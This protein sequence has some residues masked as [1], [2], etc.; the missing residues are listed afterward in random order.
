MPRPRR[1]LP[2]TERHQNGTHYVCWYDDKA[3]R[4][5]RESLGTKDDAAARTAFARFLTAGPKSTRLV[6]PAGVTV[7]QVLEWYD[8]QHVKPNVVDKERQR[9]AMTHLNAF[10]GD[11]PIARIDVEQS[12]AYATARRAGATSGRVGSDSTIRR[13]LNVLVAAATHARHWDRITDADLPRVDLPA[14]TK[15]GQVKWLTKEQIRGSLDSSTGLLHDFILIGYYTGARRASVEWL[16]KTQVDL[17][18]SRI[19]LQGPDDAVTKK[20][21]PKVPIF[22]EIRPTVERLMET[23]G[24]YLIGQRMYKP[25]VSHMADIGIEAHP[26]MLRHSRATHMLMD[27]EDPYKVAKLLGDTLATIER[28]YGHFAPEYLATKSNIGVA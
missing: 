10:M 20:R 25:F 14:E 12:R 11:T 7:R 15:G 26:H 9:D 13:E 24:D 17:R 3:R 28:V 21:R 27:G 22:P 4:T 16:R 8:T 1:T 6:G 18:H 5:L 23:S 2:W 19:D